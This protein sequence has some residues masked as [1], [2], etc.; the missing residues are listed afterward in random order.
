MEEMAAKTMSRWSPR[1]A[2]GLATTE[3]LRGDA[4]RNEELR[5]REKGKVDDD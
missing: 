2:A 4:K 5:M 3:E 1:L